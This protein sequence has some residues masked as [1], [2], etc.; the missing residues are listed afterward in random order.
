M[1]QSKDYLRQIYN[2]EGWRSTHVNHLNYTR[3]LIITL[4]TASL[5]FTFSQF[6]KLAPPIKY[7]IKVFFIA[8]VIVFTI[9]ILVGII[10][11]IRQSKVYRL[12]RH[13]SRII[14]STEAN[15]SGQ[16]DDDVFKNESK[17]CTNLE[18][19][20]EG[21]FELTLMLYFMGVIFFTVAILQLP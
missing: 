10:V 15:M 7:N 9:S 2:I 14:E 5:G 13:I 21:L 19:N 6:Q 12:Y 11:A 8:I 1:L 20:N 17:K 16:V 3:N 18:K 4:S